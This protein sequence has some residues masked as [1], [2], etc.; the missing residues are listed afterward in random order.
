MLIVSYSETQT[1]DSNLALFR[2]QIGLLP[3]AF[4]KLSSLNNLKNCTKSEPAL[5]CI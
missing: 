4:S 2:I 1:I 5:V 3:S